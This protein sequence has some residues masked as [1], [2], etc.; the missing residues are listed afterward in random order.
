M[1]FIKC[2]LLSVIIIIGL[3]SIKS[4]GDKK[5]IMFDWREVNNQKIKTVCN[6]VYKDVLSSNEYFISI[7]TDLRIINSH[8]GT[9]DENIF[10]YSSSLKNL[11]II[12]S[13]VRSIE[14]KS[15]S[16]LPNL[17]SL[18]LSLNEIYE[19]NEY[20]FEDLLNLTELILNDNFIRIIDSYSFS[21][22]INL[23][24]LELKNN[25]LRSVD[26]TIF[27]GLTNVEIIDLSGN[28]LIFIT[29]NAFDSCNS[30]KRL[31]LER[32]EESLVP[33]SLLS[34]SSNVEVIFVVSE[35]KVQHR[36]KNIISQRYEIFRKEMLSLHEEHY[37]PEEEHPPPMNVMKLN[38]LSFVVFVLLFVFLLLTVLLRRMQLAH[39]MRKD[40][41]HIGKN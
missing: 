19:V 32:T 17:E 13:E 2:A 15:F 28:P 30:L 9:I 16:N 29:E 35:R 11:S 39:V 14:K 41:E 36:F 12:D 34:N 20:F 18:D 3:K 40:L 37:D 27:E 7:S 6:N 1:Y 23:K 24:S 22:L 21:N 38:L 26:H 8:F 25:D 31:V 5:C 4:Q 10:K 33:E